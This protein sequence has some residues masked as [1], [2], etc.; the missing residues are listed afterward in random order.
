[1][2]QFATG[3]LM[4]TMPGGPEL[5]RFAD[6]AVGADDRFDGVSDDE[7]L[8]VLCAWDRVAVH[9]TARKYAAVAELVRRRPEPGS[10]LAGQARM[11]PVWEEFAASELCA[12]LGESRWEAVDMLSLAHDLE[13]KLPGTK[14]AF[15]DGVVNEAEV[16]IIASAT[17]ALASN[18]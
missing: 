16:E 4:D 1:V 14:A 8:G 13:V 15:L 12:V 3:M 9:A 18:C 7:L 2:R 5:A 10:A 11:P 6:E 17:R